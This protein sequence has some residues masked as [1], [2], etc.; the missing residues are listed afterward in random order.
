[1]ETYEV[2]ELGIEVVF[3]IPHRSAINYIVSLADYLIMSGHSEVFI[4]R[5]LKTL[6]LIAYTKN[7]Y[8]NGDP[9]IIPDVGS[10]ET[11]PLSTKWTARRVKKLLKNMELDLNEVQYV[12]LTKICDDYKDE[13]DPYVDTSEKEEAKRPPGAVSKSEIV[14]LREEAKKLFGWK[15]GKWLRKNLKEDK[16]VSENEE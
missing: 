6:R 10:G 15:D 2:E 14:S 13:V 16:N 4:T 8:I 1:M 7:L 3:D 5:V 12:V 9:V 11:I